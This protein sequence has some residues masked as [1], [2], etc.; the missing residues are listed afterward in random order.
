MLRAKGVV[1]LVVVV[2][3][4]LVTRL[5]RL[6]DLPI[7]NDEAFFLQAGRA[8]LAD[9]S[10]NIFL[11]FSDGKE[12]LFFWALALWS[13][14]FGP[15]L[16]FARLFS[17]G[18]GLLTLGVLVRLTR[19]LLDTDWWF[20]PVA[21]FVTSPFLLLTSRLAT[22]ESFLVGVLTF[23]LY[24]LFVLG[25]ERTM[26]NAALLGLGILWALL[27]KTNALAFLVF[28]F[29]LA[30]Y[31][32]AKRREGLGLFVG[33]VVLALWLYGV[34]LV[35][36]GG[37]SILAHESSYVGLGVDIV[38]NLKQ[39]VKWL[40]GYQG[41]PMVT[42]TLLGP[43]LVARKR[44]VL[45]LC[46]WL[47]TFGPIVAQ[48]TVAK[49]FFPRYFIFSLVPM[50]LLAGLMAQSFKKKALGG[51]VF[52]AIVVPNVALGSAMLSDISQAP[53]PFIERWQYVSGW[54]A[55]FGVSEVA[56]Y[57]GRRDPPKIV[58]ED[59]MI[60]SSGLVYFQPQLAGQIEAYRF[61]DGDD[62]FPSLFLGKDYE[63][64]L[65]V[66]TRRQS[67]PRDWPLNKAIAFLRPGGEGIFVYQRNK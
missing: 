51:V 48:A 54:P 4:Y 16:F 5:Y 58:S 28:L 45:A 59:L 42:L 61:V 50:S 1:V 32:L 63:E 53:L 19:R 39:A 64:A 26:A 49:I 34:V 17:V 13:N 35:K 11:S 10:A 56:D 40:T 31:L 9:P 8:I 43:L 46:L 41:W 22:Q 57:L 30:V 20:F 37:G 25:E 7:F 6:G 65:F 24:R 21:F 18:M 29:P 67:L 33:A 52:L 38:T 27:T 55:G 23:V 14:F 62:I 36:G 2:A 15:T 12:P 3:S 60:L 66:F 44:R 47:A